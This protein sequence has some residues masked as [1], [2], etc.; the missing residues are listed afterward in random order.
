MKKYNFRPIIPKDSKNKV[1]QEAIDLL[2]K[3]KI[4]TTPDLKARKTVLDEVI[5]INPVREA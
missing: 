2:I 3:E 1:R 4:E 5:K